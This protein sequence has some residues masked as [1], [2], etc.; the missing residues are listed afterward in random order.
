MHR[1][2][3]AARNPDNVARVSFM[4]PDYAVAA[5]AAC[6]AFLVYMRT[7]APTVTGE[8]SGELITAAY[9]LGVPHPPGYPLWCLA[10]HVFTWLPWGSVAWR[11]NLSSAFFS[12]AT[13][14]FVALLIVHLTRNRFAALAGALALAFSKTF[15]AHAVVA[16]VYALNALLIALCTLLIWRWRGHRRD[17]RL[18]AFALVYGLGL[19]NHNTMVLLGPVFAAYILWADGLDP[20]RWRAYARAALLVLLGL[21]VYLYLPLAS[22]ANPPMDWGNPSRSGGSGTT[23]RA[24]SSASCTRNTLAA[25]GAI[26][27]NWECARDSGRASSRRPSS[28]SASPGGGCCGAGS[29]LTRCSPSP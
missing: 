29:A 1:D 16:E 26:S 25:S 11:V 6:A 10:A 9:A 20:A 28:S 15:W 21:C 24:S 12:A 18:Y 19:A 7:L 2:M 3:T 5:A 23:R 27:A 14:F 17:S 4:G 22:R 13:V 8:D